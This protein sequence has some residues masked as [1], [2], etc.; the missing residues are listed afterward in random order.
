MFFQTLVDLYLGDCSYECFF[1]H[2]HE[3]FFFT[4]VRFW[5]A[6][7]F[8]H[9]APPSF[10]KEFSQMHHSHNCSK[11]VHRLPR[12]S[13]KPHWLLQYAGTSSSSFFIKSFGCNDSSVLSWR[14]V[15][16]VMVLSVHRRVSDFLQIPT[17]LSQMS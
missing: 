9:A 7:F 3:C 1:I 8:S 17:P 13:V 16:Q 2:S 10:V 15:G 5:S 4:L 12:S 11:W 14:H 6:R